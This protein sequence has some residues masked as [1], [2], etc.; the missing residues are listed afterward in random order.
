[1]QITEFVKKKYWE[2]LVDQKRAIRDY[3]K[4]EKD[5]LKYFA[6]KRAKKTWSFDF[7]MLKK[8]IIW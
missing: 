2:K 7:Q 4:N 3:N 5:K 1:M 8:N 6:L